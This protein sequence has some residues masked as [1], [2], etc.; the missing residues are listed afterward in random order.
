MGAQPAV[1]IPRAFVAAQGVGGARDMGAPAEPI[2]I[3]GAAPRGAGWPVAARLY[4][5]WWQLGVNPHGIEQA[6]LVVGDIIE[7]VLYTPAGEM[8]GT[9][10]FD[11]LMAFGMDYAGQCLRV[12]LRGT[13]CPGL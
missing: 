2:P 12:K 6:G 8:Q 10:V 5:H 3:M 7:V 4:D 9:P 13:S 1:P 11:V